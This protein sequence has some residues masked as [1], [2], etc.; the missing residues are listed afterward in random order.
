MLCEKCGKMNDVNAEN[1]QYCSAP[2]PGK[3]AC[4]GFGDI[5]DYEAI[6]APQNKTTSNAGTGVDPV[7]IRNLSKQVENLK[8]ANKNSAVLSMC[9]FGVSLVFLIA[10]LIISFVSGLDEDDL[11]KYVLEDDVKNYIKIEDVE[12]SYVKKSEF[13]ELKKQVTESSAK[14]D[15]LSEHKPD[16]E[17][18]EE[19]T[20]NGEF[21]Y[22]GA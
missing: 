6:N 15:E 7:E 14:T 22:N 10:S 12:K 9:A 21:T 8:K 17:S 5:L 11:G 16:L 13:N 3:S 1:C 19:Q 20:E 2:L 4:G 18:V